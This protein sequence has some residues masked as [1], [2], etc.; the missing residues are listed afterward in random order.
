M[1]LKAYFKETKHRYNGGKN[2]L[3]WLNFIGCSIVYTI[4]VASQSNAPKSFLIEWFVLCVIVG[5]E[6]IDFLESF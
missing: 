6:R 5:S 1:V 4:M 2:S 3:D